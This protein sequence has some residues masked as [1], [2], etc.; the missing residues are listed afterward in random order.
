MLYQSNIINGDGSMV[1]INKNNGLDKALQGRVKCVKIS[2]GQFSEERI[3]TFNAKKGLLTAIFPS[4][5]VDMGEKTIRV[6]V[7]AQE[8]DE[9]LVELSTPT[10]TTGSKV[11]FPKDAVLLEGSTL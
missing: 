1:M 11:W 2:A 10:F 5:Y 4:S 8:Q 7:I 9:F 3:V 6:F